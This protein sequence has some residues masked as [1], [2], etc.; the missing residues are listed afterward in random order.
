MVCCYTVG[1]DA[2]G[3]LS[4]VH[5]RKTGRKSLQTHRKLNDMNRVSS[6]NPRS[7]PS[8]IPGLVDGDSQKGSVRPT[9]YETYTYVLRHTE[10]IGT[11]LAKVTAQ[12]VHDFSVT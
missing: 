4:A 10:P 3:K 8:A 9:T 5:L 11:S 1:R 7:R 12:H 2:T 6:S